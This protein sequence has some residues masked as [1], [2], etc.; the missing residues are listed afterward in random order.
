MRFDRARHDAPCSVSCS[1]AN[2][3]LGP[4]YTDG[5][6]RF[7]KNGVEQG[8]SSSFPP[9]EG[10]YVVAC[11][12]A[13]MDRLAIRFAKS[14][15]GA[16]VAPGPPAR[17]PSSQGEELLPQAE[18][19][20]SDGSSTHAFAV[21]AHEFPGLSTAHRRTAALRLQVRTLTGPFMAARG[22]QSVGFLVVS[23][24]E[25]SPTQPRRQKPL[26]TQ[27]WQRTSSAS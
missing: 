2:D 9:G 17:Q 11:L 24:H 12:D 6:V 7:F 26:R 1:L 22:M 10:L 21:V 25:H 27:P 18:P 5:I 20:A 15:P 14:L 23:A 8:R 3:L 13:G 4:D 19:Y 16:T